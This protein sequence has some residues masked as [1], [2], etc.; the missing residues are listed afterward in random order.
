M[1]KEEVKDFISSSLKNAVIYIHYTYLS[2]KY[3]KELDYQRVEEI[4]QK[5]L[6]YYTSCSSVRIREVRKLLNDGGI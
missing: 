2:D 1:T 3:K 4:L 6:E 5:R